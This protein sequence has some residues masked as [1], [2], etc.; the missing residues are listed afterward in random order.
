MKTIGERIKQLRESRGLASNELANILDM[1]ISSYSKLENDK[2]SIGVTEL[3][4]ITEHFDVSADDIL[5]TN[6]SNQDIV[7]YMKREKNMSDKDIKGVQMIISMMDEAVTLYNM[8][9]RI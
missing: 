7:M 8:K 4:K 9:E 5:G 2:K 1:S 6:K 3:R